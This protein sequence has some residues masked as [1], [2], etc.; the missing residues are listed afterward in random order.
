MT[1]ETLVQSNRTSYEPP[2]LLDKRGGSCPAPQLLPLTWDPSVAGVLAVS[3]AL[4]ADFGAEHENV[5]EV[6]CPRGRHQPQRS[7]RA[8]FPRLG[9]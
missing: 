7:G 1:A 8:P 5:P 2:L 9:S 6:E 4:F 3:R